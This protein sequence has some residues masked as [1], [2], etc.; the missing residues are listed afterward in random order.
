MG[1]IF[2]FAGGWEWCYVDCWVGYSVVL[3]WSV[4]KLLG[5]DLV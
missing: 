3:S 5:F 2:C 1:F 4:V